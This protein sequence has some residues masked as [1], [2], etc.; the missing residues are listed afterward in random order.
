LTPIPK[1]DSLAVRWLRRPLRRAM[2]QA[3][4]NLLSVPS[5]RSPRASRPKILLI[6]PDHLGDL[7]FLTPALKFLREQ[8]SEAH[9]TLL[10]GPWANAV[11]E[12]NPHVDEIQ[13]LDF[14]GFTRQAKSS[15]IAPYRQLRENARRLRAQ[16]FD[17]AVILRFDHWWGAWLAA[18]ARIPR[19]IGYGVPE[20]KPFLSDVV[21][22]AP[23]LHEVAQNLRLVARLAGVPAPE[24]ISPDLK[25]LEFYDT[26]ADDAAVRQLLQSHGIA[27]SE[28]FALLVPGSG[29]AV[30]LWRTDA[31]AHVADALADRRHFKVVIVGAGD[32]DAA[33]AKQIAAEARSP[34][35]NLCGQTSLAQLAAL[36][37]RAALALGTDSG[38][39]HL[40]VAMGTPSVHL[41]GPV[42]AQAFGP[43]GDPSRHVVLTSGL[44]CIPCNRLDYTAAEAPAHPC[45]RLIGEQ[46]VMAAVEKVML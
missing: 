21:P 31:F 14:P 43:W 34:I 7:L 33:L 41:F 19:R 17:A 36:F 42:S 3:A 29:A 6:R 24:R 10:V 16:P 4:G 38:P 27:P 37:R 1:T 23:G 46:Q 35:L 8:M 28:C 5:E 11:V 9:I 13:T 26:P 15:F 2:L 40:A 22:Y 25:P 45:V 44:A 39:M 20:V 30:K 12:H 32:A 18:L